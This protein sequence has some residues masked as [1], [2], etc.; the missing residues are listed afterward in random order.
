MIFVSSNKHIQQ[1][2]KVVAF[3]K[4]KPDKYCC[5][6]VGSK[7]KS[8]HLAKNLEQKLNSKLLTVDVIHIHGSLHKN[9]SSGSLDFFV[10]RLMCLSSLVGY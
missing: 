6:F 5:V 3:V 10:Q 8:F 2:D 9:E 4:K 1:L 7:I